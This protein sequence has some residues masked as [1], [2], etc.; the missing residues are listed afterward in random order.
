MLPLQKEIH[1]EKEGLIE[2]Y[3]YYANNKKFIQKN[4]R[5]YEIDKSENKYTKLLYNRSNISMDW[6]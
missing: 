3:E 5:S 4:M 6:L 2:K 1:N